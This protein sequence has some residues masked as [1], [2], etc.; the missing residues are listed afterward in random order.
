MAVLE[1]NTSTYNTLSTGDCITII[2]GIFVFVSTCCESL[3]YFLLGMGLIA[4]TGFC[5][6]PVLAAPLQY[7]LTGPLQKPLTTLRACVF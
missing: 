6:I 4:S 3:Y 5:G 1:K 7:S 2:Y